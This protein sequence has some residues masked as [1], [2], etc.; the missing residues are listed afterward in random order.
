MTLKGRF[1]CTK[2][3]NKKD[4]A[5]NKTND[6]VYQCLLFDGSEAIKVRNVN[7]ANLK[8]G[9]PVEVDVKVYPGDY[10]ISYVAEGS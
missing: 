7:G 5:G 4:K 10:G 9:D 2:N 8:F 3:Y 1:L 6:I